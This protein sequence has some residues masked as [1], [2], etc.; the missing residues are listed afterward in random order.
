MLELVEGVYNQDLLSKRLQGN[1]V[2]EALTITLLFLSRSS[3][4]LFTSR[5]WQLAL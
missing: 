5:S 1:A 4:V 3:I 2:K